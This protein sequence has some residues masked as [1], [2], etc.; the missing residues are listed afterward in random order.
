MYGSHILNDGED[1]G[2]EVVVEGSGPVEH[3]RDGGDIA[4]RADAKR[5]DVKATAAS[6]RS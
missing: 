5:R 6:R 2:L 3:E 4:A 1:G